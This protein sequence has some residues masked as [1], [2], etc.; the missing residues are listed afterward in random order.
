MKIT[1]FGSYGQI[2]ENVDFANMSDDEWLE[3]AKSHLTSLLTIFKNP[4]GLTPD[5]FINRI[6]QCGP[7]KGS[8]RAHYA[9]KYGRIIDAFDP[10]SLEGVTLED[11]AFLLSRTHMIEVTESGKPISRIYGKKDKDGNMLGSFDSG[12]LGW[13]CNESSRLTF[14]PEVALLGSKNMIGSATGFVQTADFYESVTDTFRSELDDMVLIH[15]YKQG[16]ISPA[17]FN[18][19]LFSNQIRLNF[20]PEDDIETPLVLTSP[21]GIKGLHYALNSAYKVKGMSDE[22]SDKLFSLINKNVISSKYTYYHYYEN[23][24]DMLMFDNSVTL[25]CRVKGDEDRMAYRIQYEP[26]NLYDEPWYP[27]HQQEFLDR[28]IAQTHELVEILKLDNFKLPKK[29]TK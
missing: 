24:N 10:K 19:P 21:G 8:V 27:Y 1:G 3:I 9:K 11:K 17:E 7:T 25:H 18:N 4:I 23:N 22:E 13:H 26:C 6:A 12:D 5:G 20:C 29:V 14:A 15:K 2:L 16:F 28:Y